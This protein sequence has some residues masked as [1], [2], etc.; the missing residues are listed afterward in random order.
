MDYLFN[1]TGLDRI[2][3]WYLDGNRIRKKHFPNRT[4]IFVTGSTH[5]LEFLGHQLDDAAWISYDWQEMKDIYGYHTG[6]RVDLKPS[7]INR[8]VGAIDT[9]GLGRKFSVF[10]ADI[11]ASLRFLS[12][13]KLELFPLESPDSFDVIPEAVTIDATLS[14]KDVRK[15]YLDGR[16]LDP[17]RR[18]SYAE[19]AQ[20]INESILII[21]GNYGGQT[22]AILRRIGGHGYNLPPYRVIPGTSFESYGQVHYNCD[23]ISFGGK[24]SIESSSFIFSEAGVPGMVEMSRT[25]SV[26]LETVSV[27]TPGTAV[28]SMEVSYA[29]RNQ[30]LVPLYKNDHEAEKTISELVVMDRGGLVL[31]P[32]P[33]IYT[34]VHE[35]DFSSMYPSIIA[36]YNLS[37][38]TISQNGSIEVPGASYR[39]RT[40]RRGFLSEA[41]SNLLARRLY[42]KSVR[43]LDPVY[44]QRDIALKWMLLTSFGYTGYKNAKFGRIEVHEA[45]TSLGRWALKHAMKL[46]ESMGFTVIHGIVDSLWISGKG[47]VNDLLRRIKDETRIDIVLEGHYQWILFLP[48]RSGIGALNRYIGLK[49]DGRY[50]VRGIEI[51]RRDVPEICRKFQS[52]AMEIFRDCRTV[53][54]IV[55]MR[56]RYESLKRKYLEGMAGFPQDYF[57]L[58]ISPSRRLEEYRVN[59]IS[60][61]VMRKWKSMGREIRPGETVNVKVVN[62]AMG[63][64]EPVDGNGEID[65]HF[66][67]KYLKR[68]FEAFDFL[69]EC[70]E[71]TTGSRQPLNKGLYFF[72]EN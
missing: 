40:D 52:E 35:I 62:W 31:Q 55:L 69:L 47:D 61:M 45:I 7:W 6:I 58:R 37:P 17:G 36:R 23:R 28:S 33:G 43:D 22:S 64:V 29:L 24:I 49:T 41:L 67:T 50:K 18:E 44:A 26:P 16:K 60:R 2:T 66:Y 1:A 19:I 5:D 15:L 59:N 8:M 42:Y 10:N 30:V 27:I 20:S 13:K 56:G 14:G 25:S 57:F 21:Y 51:R 71:E 65:Y 3:L 34:D 12:E 70:A 38:E 48:S 46:A 72:S 68:A 63:I 54:S 11:N 9:I 39:V 32:D 53:S 4:W